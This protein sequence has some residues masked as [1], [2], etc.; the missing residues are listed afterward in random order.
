MIARDHSGTSVLLMNALGKGSVFTVLAPTVS[1][2]P[3]AGKSRFVYDIIDRIVKRPG[4]AVDITPKN[5]KVEFILSKTDNREAVVFLMNH[6]EKAWKGTVSI[7]LEKSGLSKHLGETVHAKVCKGYKEE[8]YSSEVTKKDNKLFV[9][10]HL[11]GKG[12][13]FDPHYMASFTLIRIES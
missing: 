7:D 6:G 10:T 2:I 13:S 12:K 5:D 3:P 9:R 4:L 1:G 8:N 11:Y